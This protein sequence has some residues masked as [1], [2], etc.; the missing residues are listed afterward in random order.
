MPPLK[1]KRTLTAKQI[2][3][4]GKWIDQGWDHHSSLVSSLPKKAR[5]VVR[6]LAALIKDLKMRGLLDETLI[7]WS[8]EFGRT[9]MAQGSNA[10]G[11]KTKT[12][13][14]H[15]K[16]AYSVWMAGG[17]V[18]PGHSHG[19]T[20][21]FGYGIVEDG[22]HIHDFNATLM[23][24]LGIDHERLTFRYQGLRLRLTSVHGKVCEGVL[25]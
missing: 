12:G 17:G 7:V 20:D 25:A 6:P 3:L 24:L 19:I 1:S 5:Q 18:K 8:A 10:D 11:K 23:R 22:V 14:D 15:H 13:R 16:E 21:E 4:L 2:E 9:P